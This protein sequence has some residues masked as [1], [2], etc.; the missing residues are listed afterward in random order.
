MAAGL[1]LS[2]NLINKHMKGQVVVNRSLIEDM[3]NMYESGF[4]PEEQV[5]ALIA[6][7]EANN[8]E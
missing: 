1:E 4:E 8:H 5:E 3:S 2:I 6:M 7:L